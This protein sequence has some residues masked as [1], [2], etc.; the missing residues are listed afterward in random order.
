MHLRTE[1]S[2]EMCVTFAGSCEISALDVILLSFVTT[3]TLVTCQGDFSACL[4]PPT[5]SCHMSV[6]VHYKNSPETATHKLLNSPLK[7]R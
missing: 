5:L 1:E 2:P 3:E 4:P 6:I 7:Q